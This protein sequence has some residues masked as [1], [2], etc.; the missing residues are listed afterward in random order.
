M[1]SSIPFAQQVS[2]MMNKFH[3]KF[4]PRVEA[5][6]RY[7]DAEFHIM[8]PGDFVRCAITGNPILL[9]NL[10]YWNV[11]RQEPYATPAASLEGHSRSSS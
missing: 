1:A 6:L 2:I 8:T 11:D 7:D 9:E 3:K 10:K 4:M 5:V